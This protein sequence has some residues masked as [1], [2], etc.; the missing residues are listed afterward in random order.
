MAS[1]APKLVMRLSLLASV[2]MLA[3]KLYAY[4][5]THSA[6]IFSDAAES[7]IHGIATAFAA[8]SLWYAAQPAD[9]NHPYGHGRIAFFSA[10]FEGALVLAAACTIIFTAIDRL[11]HGVELQNLGLGILVCSV[12]VL[13]NLVLGCALIRVGKQNDSLILIANGKHVLSDC[14]TTLAAIVGVGLVMLTGVSWLDPAAAILIG[15]MIL[16]SGASLLRRSLAGLMDSVDAET[17]QALKDTL[18][19]SVEE[20]LIL[21]FHNLRFRKTNDEIWIELH[22]LV[23]GTL[24]TIEAHHRITQMETAL[25]NRFP[26]N[27]LRVTTHIEPDDHQAA[28]PD[29]HEGLASGVDHP[30]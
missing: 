1:N 2:V 3:G 10:G 29:G 15:V 9:D 25:A 23:P 30:R 11:I 27:R 17:T 16:A 20:G 21:D 24:T 5:K 6:A 26:K 12:L 8:F 22:A 4:E 7:V 28:H 13:I 18:R 14:F 19:E